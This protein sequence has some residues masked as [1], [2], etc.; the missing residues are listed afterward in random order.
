MTLVNLSFRVLKGGAGPLFG[1]ILGLATN[2]LDAQET[3]RPNRLAWFEGFP[4]P[5]P[6]A[7]TELALESTSQMLRPDLERS[8]D[9]RTFARLDGE[10][11]QL[12]GDWALKA[13]ASRFNLRA[14]VAYRSGGIADQAIWNW[15]QF[16]NMPQGGRE[17]APKNRLVYHLERDGR[18][19]GDLSHSGW[20]LMDLDLAW[21]RPFGTV[22]AG[23]RV[24]VSIQ[25]P[26]GR[27][28]DFSGSGGTDGLVGAALWRRYAHWRIF[29]QVE[30]VWLGLPE[31][32]PLRAVM[33]QTSFSRAWTSVGWV[34]DGTGLVSGLGIEVS[35]GYAGSPYR[36]GLSRLDRAGWQQ[37][38]TFR[39]TR[40]PR[41]RFGFSEE[42]GT[43][44]APDLTGFAAYRFGD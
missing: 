37:H 4:E 38:W 41:W 8:A 34:G 30:R 14:R 33:D 32:S 17:D 31:H 24:G 12:T 39:H 44:T 23:G 36:T 6:E 43:F 13:G 20:A 26:T 2:P 10:A 40:L 11:W 28:S 1:L 9:G 35:V 21:I 15:H 5:L 19:I 7:V 42:A 29:G 27:Q 25:L 16:F 22:E 3:P 18:V